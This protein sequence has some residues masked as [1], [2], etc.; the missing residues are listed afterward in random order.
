MSARWFE[1][2][3]RIGPGAPVDLDAVL[4]PGTAPPP[5]PVA[6]R[7]RPEE[8]ARSSRLWQRDAAASH[9]G[10]RVTRLPED[11]R[12]V[13]LRLAAAATERGVVPV[14]L[15]PLPRTGFEAYG[16]RVERL[17]D[18]PPAETAR[19]EAELALFWDL[20]I[21]IDLEDVAALG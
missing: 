14:I 10:I 7:G 18:A 8:T 11:I 2:L 16:F 4:A 6:L 15:S 19:A 3:S 1:V 12:P 17:P 9:I 21:V 13:A 5:P 20:A